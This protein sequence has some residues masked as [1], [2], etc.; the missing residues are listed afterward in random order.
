LSQVFREF[1]WRYFFVLYLNF[2]VVEE[3]FS[4]LHIFCGGTSQQGS[5]ADKQKLEFEK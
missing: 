4:F 5:A 1:V 3:I 2:Y